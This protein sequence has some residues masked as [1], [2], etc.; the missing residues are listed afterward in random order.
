MLRGARARGRR[1]P[2]IAGALARI[3]AVAGPA[4]AVVILAGCWGGGGGG[5][6]TGGEAGAGVVL[7]P[8]DIEAIR[9]RHPTSLFGIPPAG[10][11]AEIQRVIDGDTVVAAFDGGRT[12]S[13]RLIGI[14]TPEKPGG[15]LPAEC[16]GAEA[17]A[18]TAALVPPGTPV[19]LT[20]GPEPRDVYDRLL[21]YVHRATDGLMVNMALAREGYAETL[22]IP[23]NTDYTPLFAAAV[24]AARAENL[25][26]WAA[27]GGPDTPLSE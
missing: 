5:A 10:A 17:G 8:P 21:A 18:F 15:R 24:A 1:R 2:G 3:T 4:V 22:S 9:A 7:A 27:C 14:D 25:G 19:L 23:P 11:R 6:G 12:E 13:V 16:F 26:L 20:G